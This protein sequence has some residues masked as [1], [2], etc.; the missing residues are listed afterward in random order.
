MKKTIFAVI[1]LTATALG[2]QAQ[3]VGFGI[4]GGLN[5]ADQNVKDISTSTITSY[6]VGA[7]LNLNITKSFG[8]TPE[9]LFTAMGSKWEDAKVNMDY[10]SIPVMIRILPIKQLSLEVGPQFSF[11]TSAKI[12]DVED[13]EKYLKSNDF[14]LAFGVGV[15][16]PLGLNIGGRYVLGFTNISDVSE[17]E[18]KNRTIQVY[19]GWTILGAK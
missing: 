7:Y 19:V 14:G 11:L 16:L 8:I 4:K 6:H 17:D 12:E 15:H 5:F 1:I 2:I 18:I 13:A 10:I 9:V 3:G